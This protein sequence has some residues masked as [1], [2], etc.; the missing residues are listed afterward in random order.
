M[1]LKTPPRTMMPNLVERA[2]ASS[3]ECVV[4]M[5][6]D[7]LSL[8]EIFSTTYHMKRRASG[9]IPAEGSSRRMIGGLPRTAIATESFLLLPPDRVPASL[10]RCAFRFS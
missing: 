5:T 4:K 1:H 3:I 10:L 9:S 6:A 8:W 2:S 7:F